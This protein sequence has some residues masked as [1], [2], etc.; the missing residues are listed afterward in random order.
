MGE[1][2]KTLSTR[3][4]MVYEQ[5]IPGLDVWDLCCDH[6][7]LWLKAHSSGNFAHIHFVDPAAHLIEVL[8]RRCDGAAGI[9]FHAISAQNT[10][11]AMQGN[12]VVA[13]VG[14]ELICEIILDLIANE[15]LEAKRLIL[16][17]HKHPNKMTSKLA[18]NDVFSCRYSHSATYSVEENG[19]QREVFVFEKK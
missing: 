6:G 13:G 4:Q 7:Y 8:K 12:V 10:E 18:C 9:S 2:K 17:P 5:L 16:V 19:K 3:L 1:F 11:I 14:A 15:K